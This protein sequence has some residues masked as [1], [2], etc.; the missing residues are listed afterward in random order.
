MEA[1][2]ES[3]APARPA[4]LYQSALLTPTRFTEEVRMH[5]TRRVLLVANRTATTVRLGEAV[6]RRAGGGSDGTRFHLLVPAT[7]RGLHR[8]VDPEVAGR[9][10]AGGQL[11]GALPSLS[12][13]A[14]SPVTGEVGDADPLA[15]IQDV[16]S[17]ERFDEI[18]ISTLPRRVSRWLRLDLPS[19]ARG[20]GLPVTHVEAEDVP[21]EAAL[22]S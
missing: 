3:I 2:E 8:V 22:A 18:I 17:R 9:E 16:L 4:C 21:D 12:A 19:K 15:A 14:G 11:D 7:P 5:E 1:I 10:E 20:L 13:A 6:E